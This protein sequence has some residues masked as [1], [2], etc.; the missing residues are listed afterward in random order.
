MSY[1]HPAPQEELVT[2]CLCVLV[3]LSFRDRA[4]QLRGS[5]RT[6]LWP[7]RR[8]PLSPR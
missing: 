8:L 3:F 1:G 5:W 4:G 7:Q 6:R 2:F